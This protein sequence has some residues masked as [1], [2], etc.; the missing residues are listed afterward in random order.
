MITNFVRRKI[1]SRLGPIAVMTVA[2]FGA[3]CS[4]QVKL[5][6]TVGAD[7]C[8]H[9]DVPGKALSTW[10]A[11]PATTD[12]N[13]S[14]RSF[15]TDDITGLEF[16]MP[17]SK[18]SELYFAAK[19]SGGL[20]DLLGPYSKEKYALTI[21]GAGLLRGI[22]QEDWAPARPLVRGNVRIAGDGEIGE[23]DNHDLPYA[24]K[25]F[26]RSGE[27]LSLATGSADDRWIAVFSYDGKQRVLSD[28][29]RGGGVPGIPGPTKHPRQG[30]LYADIYNVATGRKV[31]ALKGPFQ[32]GIGNN[33]FLTAY[34]LDDRYF[35]FNTGK[36]LEE[37]R[38][39]TICE[40]PV[41]AGK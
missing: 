26:T 4:A 34:F 20:D 3:N 23:K 6:A 7:R 1:Y 18:T 16:R 19:P 21:H 17:V 15:Q 9:I 33:W 40:L 35:F 8:R 28:Q 32:N 37:V 2:V 14:D 10:S 11:D 22:K 27:H 13:S 31:V 25:V 12:R 24:G 39:F 5:G 29:E 41:L 38:Q 30:Q 36:P